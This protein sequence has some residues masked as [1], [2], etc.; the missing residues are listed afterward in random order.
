[1]VI[2]KLIYRSVSC[3]NYL[4]ILQRSYF[5]LYKTGVLKFDSKFDCHYFVR[6]LIKKGDV[7]IDI[8]ANLGYYSIL[9]AKW[10][11]TTG[12]IY[13]VEPITV[14]NKI[15]NEKAKK[16]RQ[17]TLYPYALGEEE[18]EVELVNHGY[19]RTGLPRVY[20]AK[21]DGA[22]DHYE[23]RVKAQMK[24]ASELFENLDRIDY[25]KCDIEGYEFNVLSDIKG[26]LSK[27]K[28]IVQVEGNDIKIFDLFNELGY[29]TYRIRDRQ[30][31]L[32]ED[33]SLDG[34]YIF[35]HHSMS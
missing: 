9:F 4:R 6:N 7:I 15:F 32:V 26:L 34:D 8:G 19:L 20:D 22:I 17:I 35:I 29:N 25:I 24:K 16:Y 13:S 12:K 3:E 28:P 27:F 5:I 2:K 21:K 14:Y 33:K 31:V 18:K 23:F 10:A 30:L 1:M 11:G